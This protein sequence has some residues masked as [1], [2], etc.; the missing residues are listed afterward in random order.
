ME[1]MEQFIVVIPTLVALCAGWLVKHVIP[2]EPVYPADRGGGGC[3]DEYLAEY[4]LYPT[5]AGGRSGI[6]PCQHRHV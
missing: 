4:E 2:S 5:G 6:R 1:T 3:R